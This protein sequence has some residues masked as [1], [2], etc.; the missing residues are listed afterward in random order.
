MITD[1]DPC[2]VC[3]MIIEYEY[4]PK[5]YAPGGPEDGFDPGIHESFD[6]LMDHFIYHRCKADPE[7]IRN[8]IINE[9]VGPDDDPGDLL[10]AFE[11]GEW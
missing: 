2:P 5:D 10:A 4:D 6:A 9:I 7:R 8:F 11:R 3:D 1:T